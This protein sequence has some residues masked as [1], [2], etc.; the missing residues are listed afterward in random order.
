MSKKNQIFDDMLED[1]NIWLEIS[2][3]NSRIKN[4]M[5][6]FNIGTK[7]KLFRREKGVLGKI[8]DVLR[9]SLDFPGDKP[10]KNPNEM[11]GALKDKIQRFKQGEPNIPSWQIMRVART[12]TAAMREVA[13]LLRWYE[14]GFKKVRRVEIIDDRTGEDHRK[15]NNTI[16]DIESLLFG[17][18]RDMRIPD[19]PNC[20]GRYQLEE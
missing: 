8:R 20:R 6:K 15:L 2:T 3:L 16:W 4:F 19:R 13:K 17:K 7:I 11:A 12:E 14:L 9:K 10:D 18:D 1:D 5:K